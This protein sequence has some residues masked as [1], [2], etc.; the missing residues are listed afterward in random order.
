VKY[1][2]EGDL[3]GIIEHPKERLVPVL[4]IPAAATNCSIEL[5]T[6]NA[7]FEYVLSKV[8][9]WR[10]SSRS[11]GLSESAAAARKGRSRILRL[12]SSSST[13]G[14]RGR[15]GGLCSCR[16]GKAPA[17]PPRCGRVGASSTLPAAGTRGGA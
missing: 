5:S 4:T 10:P 7:T 3:D 12:F 11:T 15:A 2:R 9:R 6:P 14:R 17:R 13:P 1:P 8:K 16:R